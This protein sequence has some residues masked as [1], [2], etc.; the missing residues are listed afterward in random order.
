[1]SHICLPRYGAENRLCWCGRYV[2]KPQTVHE[3]ALDTAIANGWTLHQAAEYAAG[4][5]ANIVR[6][7]D[8]RELLRA[9]KTAVGGNVGSGS[10]A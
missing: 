9:N 10:V 4:P 5:R 1:M 2:P 6:L 8:H 7:A 3:L